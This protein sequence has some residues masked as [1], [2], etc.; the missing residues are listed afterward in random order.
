MSSISQ[1]LVELEGR[2]RSLAESM[3]RLR[4]ASELHEESA[5][6]LGE[7]SAG[8]ARL[9]VD[10]EALDQIPGVK[11]SLDK[12]QVSIDELR[13]EIS[14]NHEAVSQIPEQL[15]SVAT[16]LTNNRD[17]LAALG[18]LPGLEDA[19]ASASERIEALTK[20]AKS[21]SKLILS[22]RAW[23]RTT[24]VVS[25][26]VILILIAVAASLSK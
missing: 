8:V 6:H 22:L 25:G 1:S 12:L 4:S 18:S 3:E 26:V 17:A 7:L 13:V 2:L 24:L 19:V 10:V 15:E 23:L 5:K 14:K 21:N 16:A 11:G 20:E 9:Q